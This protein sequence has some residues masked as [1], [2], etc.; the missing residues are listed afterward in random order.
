LRPI[1]PNPLIPTRIV[2][3]HNLLVDP[4]DRAAAPRLSDVLAPEGRQAQTS[5]V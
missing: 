2:T 5:K 1:R 3:A 4:G